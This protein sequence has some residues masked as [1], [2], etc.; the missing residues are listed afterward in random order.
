MRPSVFLAA[1]SGLAFVGAQSNTVPVTGLLGN[2]SIVTD[3]PVGVT[4]KATLPNKNT[5]GIRGSVSGTANSNGT[6]VVFTVDLSGFPSSGGP[7]LYHIH[8]TPVPTDGNCT[9]TLGHLDPTE[10]GEMPSCDPTQPE[11]CQVGDLAGKH[12]KITTSPFT[13]SYLDLYP[14]T[15]EGIGAFFGNRSLVVHFGNTTRITCANFTLVSNSTGGNGTKPTS[16]APVPSS[17]TSAAAAE[18]LVSLATVFAGFA[19]SFFL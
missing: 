17:Y 3:N 5:T 18:T 6:G 14:S 4:Y 2:A 8:S 9:G 16:P 12:G 15:K 19:A 1:L 13:A 10:R 7:F 11:T